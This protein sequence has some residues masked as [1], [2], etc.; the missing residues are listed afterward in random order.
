MKKIAIYLFACITCSLTAQTPK[1]YLN[2]YAWADFHSCHTIVQKSDSNY[3]LGCDV[4]IATQNDWSVSL[5]EINYQNTEILSIASNADAVSSSS[6]QDL[7]HIENDHYL[8]IGF[9]THEV[10]NGNRFPHLLSIDN[11]VFNPT[12]PMGDVLSAVYTSATKAENGN[13]WAS[14]GNRVM[15]NDLNLFLTK[16]NTNGTLIFDT[17][18]H[19]YSTSNNDQI[20]KIIPTTDGN[21]LLLTTIDDLYWQP[22]GDIMLLKINE[23]GDIIWQQV[24]D[25]G[26]D[27]E[28]FDIIATLDGGYL[29]T[30]V[31]NISDYDIAVGHIVK[32]KENGEEEWH[33]QQSFFTENDYYFGYPTKVLQLLDGNYLIA[34]V[35]YPPNLPQYQD[36]D[37]LVR[38]NG[39]LVKLDNNGELLWQRIYHSEANDYVYDLIPDQNDLTGN[40]GYVMCG[41]NDSTDYDYAY[42]LKVNCMGLLTEPQAAFDYSITDN[43]IQLTNTSQYVYPDSIDGGYFIWDFGDG[44]PIFQTESLG[45]VQH[46]YQS[47]GDYTVHLTAIVCND[48][49]VYE[50]TIAIQAVGVNEITHT[51]TQLLI[52]PNPTNGQSIISYQLPFFVPESVIVVY[53]LYGQVVRQYEISDITGTLFLDSA[54]LASGLYFVSIEA[55]GQRLA[56][57]KIEVI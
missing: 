50:Q 57:E 32:I 4:K 1:Y 49:S 17:I 47:Q 21:Y 45:N 22:P 14:G 24:Y 38:I 56:F 28:A 12:F 13:I 31:T 23:S 39:T 15:S 7:I 20:N 40:S 44:S 19:D 11:G 18:Y 51:K 3:I 27:E 35:D 6:I 54:T 43:L 55:D 2:N 41:R 26:D 34:G 53:N 46:S 33:L 29:F 36:T 8:G 42:L 25:F 5:V 37:G 48:T 30:S 10:I 16:L 9:A 52:S